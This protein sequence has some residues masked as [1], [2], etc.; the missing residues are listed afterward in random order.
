MKV[1][2]WGEEN[3]YLADK[4]MFENIK[5]A[6]YKIEHIVIVP[7]R[8][9]LLTEKE[10]LK[11]LNNGILF[12]VKVTSFSKLAT[13]ILSEIG[14][15]KDVLTSADQL[16]ILS[17]AVKNTKDEFTYFKKDNITFCDKLLK[18]ISLLQSSRIYPQDILKEET[19]RVTNKK[20]FHDI[21]LVYKEYLRLLEEKMDSSLV[22]EEL[23]ANPFLLEG[24]KNKVVY[25]AGFDS[26]TSQM[27]DLIKI[28]IE[29]AKEVNVSFANSKS[30][31][32]QFIYE[33]DVKNKIIKICSELSLVAKVNIGDKP[34]GYVQN[35]LLKNLYSCQIETGGDSDSIKVVSAF[36]KR[37]E[38]ECVAKVIASKIRQGE[39]LDSF[40]VAVSEIDDYLS[41]MEE[42]FEKYGFMFYVDKSIKATQTVLARCIFSLLEVKISNYS[43]ESLLNFLTN[44]LIRGDKQTVESILKIDIDGYWKFLNFFEARNE[45]EE[46]LK[47]LDDIKTNQSLFELIEKFL[48]KLQTSYNDYLNSLDKNNLYKEKNIEAQ[49][50][51]CFIQAF[52]VV[53]EHVDPKE[54][55]DIKEFSK[56]LE[57]ILSTKELSSV[58]TL[59]DGIMIGDATNSFFERK[60]FL[61]LLGGEKLPKIIEDSSLLSDK[62]IENPIYK[63][64][65]QPT[66]KMINRRNRFKLFNLLSLNWEEM[67]LSYLCIG[68]DGK[69]TAKPAYIEQIANLFKLKI[70]N[71]SHIFEGENKEENLLNEV[72]CI[73]NLETL[74]LNQKV[75]NLEFLDKGS[76]ST[77]N[78][79]FRNNSVS[80]SQLETYFSCPFKHFVK[81]G[82]RLN[83]KENMVIDQRDIGNVSHKAVEL[84]VNE[85][86]KNNFHFEYG[87]IAN[88]LDKNFDTILEKTKVKEK[89]KI[90]KEEEG[91]KKFLEIQ[92]KNILTRVCKEMS[93]SLYKPYKT[94]LMLEKQLFKDL[95]LNFIGKIDR[96]D[97][98]DRFFR[99]IDYK[100]GN[101]QSILKELYYGNKIQLFLYS[102]VIK[103]KLKKECGGVFYFDCKFD[104]QEV[105]S[106]KSIL[107]GLVENNDENLK[108]FD[109]SL[110]PGTKSDILS[111][112]IS[113]KDPKKYIGNCISKK[114]LDFYIEY[115]L[116]LTRKACEEIKD[117][118]IK[119]SPD[120]LSCEYCNYKE[121]CCY[122]KN[123][124]VRVK[125]F[126]EE[127]FD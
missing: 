104:F 124:G 113:K 75:E 33:E 54:K 112:G 4:Y 64:V 53:K 119:A 1:S 18:A 83:E 125:N 71:A 17:K 85:C 92:I 55:L 106:G 90:I 117:G 45:N 10:L 19:E 93:A 13:E 63:K 52:S 66:S 101:L 42:I 47:E 79:F 115:A 67:Y 46:F 58:P 95:N 56:E 60:K 108:L 3:L 22:F 48:C 25:F 89:L 9:S 26:F 41:L 12:N 80:S 50:L 59:V 30:L 98:T 72:G 38:V 118:F 123:L 49:S 81:Y 70:L 16:L 29:S 40:V 44:P 15:E 88:F 5:N 57:L 11:T 6:D 111:L 99:I 126:K 73:K 105:D 39:K 14:R 87:T 110:K 21:A 84:F 35:L 76:L 116:N 103:E 86:I 23:L 94:E 8:A 24:M 61:F 34:K 68:E 102:N 97:I 28:L 121:I 77:S 96:V 120:N 107:K 43:K 91:F 127:M 122:N 2:L 20:K 7:D 32:N 69:P 65:V 62:D 36:T 109:K 27:Y 82:L 51:D 78:L 100:T 114:S 74:F 37:Q 31:G